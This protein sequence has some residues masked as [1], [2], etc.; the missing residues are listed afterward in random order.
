MLYHTNLTASQQATPPL[1]RDGWELT[2]CACDHATFQQS[3]CRKRKAG[4]TVIAKVRYNML[5]FYNGN[6][7]VE[8]VAN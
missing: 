1:A 5:I 8:L 6:C 7:S 4:D 3:Y 2:I